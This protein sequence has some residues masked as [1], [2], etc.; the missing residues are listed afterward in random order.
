MKTA[1]RLV[2]CSFAFAVLT[3]GVAPPLVGVASAAT[4]GASDP[5][6]QIVITG[7]VD[8]PAG[9]TIDHVLIF[10]GDVHVK[11]R[12]RDWVV[13]LNGDVTV[14]GRVGGSVTSANGRVVVTD[15]GSVGGD[16]ISADKPVIARRD[17]V[18]GNVDRFRRRFAL[19]RLAAVGRIVLWIAATVSS[20]LLGGF[21]LLVAPRAA[22]GAALAG[23][24]A[25]GPAIGLGFAVAIGAPI[26]GVLL[27]VTIV[28]LPLGLATLGALGLLY[29][30]G[31]VSGAFFLGRLIF[32]EPRN[33]LVA[34][35]IG[36]GILRV[37]AI[38]PVLGVLALLAATIYGLG[39]L[40]VAAF[41]A[42]RGV[43]E[44][45]PTP[46]AP[47]EGAPAGEGGDAGTPGAPSAA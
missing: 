3:L 26:V 45:A 44:A 2:A 25:V 21:L 16:V 6:N 30:F 23:R 20:F 37:V 42:R 18:S 38:V 35:L 17:S 43:P 19:G 27:A 39:C 8:V 24:R 4:R 10:N 41:R 46:A 32:G 7:S 13:A 12:V 14:S 1:V 15:S 11:G 9:T 33:R 29:G 47:T 22:E 31:Y 5:D 28:G 40:T 34:F 36:W